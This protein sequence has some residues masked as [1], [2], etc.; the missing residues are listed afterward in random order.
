MLNINKVSKSIKSKKILKDI[1]LMALAGQV[2]FLLGE[3]GTGKSTLLRILNGLES[4]NSGTITVDGKTLNAANVHALVNLVF[5]H[6]NLFLHLTVLENITLALQHV[7]HKTQQEAEHIARTLLEKYKLADKAD[8]SVSSL[9][10]GQKQRLAIARAVATNPYVICLDEPT[11]AL[12]PF[13]TSHVAQQIQQLADEGRI[14]LVATHDM[15]LV[16]N[17]NVQGIVHLMQQGEIIET[18]STAE[19]KSDANKFKQ[20]SI[21]MKGGSVGF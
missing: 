19:I 15:N 5:Q 20:L 3:S 2:T 14:V 6:F 13:L 11:S 12:D 16:M 4:Y 1:S 10:G 17:S 18:A 7:H 21:F 9:S 8:A